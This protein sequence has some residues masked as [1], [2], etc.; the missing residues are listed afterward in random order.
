MRKNCASGNYIC[1]KELEIRDKESGL[2]LIVS[3]DF[4]I[5]IDGYR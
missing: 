2:L 4:S 5:E 3:Q 1:T